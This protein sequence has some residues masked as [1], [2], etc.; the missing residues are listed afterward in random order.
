MPKGSVANFA[1]YADENRQIIKRFLEGKVKTTSE[2]ETSCNHKILKKL[3]RLYRSC[4]NE[5]EPDRHGIKP[6]LKIV[7]EIRNHHT[8]SFHSS[9]PN[10]VGTVWSLGCVKEE[11]ICF[12][13][14][15]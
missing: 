7:E 13:R 9:G 14:I 2:S 3:R 10:Q 15:Y 5:K 4:L 11:E 1:F 8:Y 12:L 6:L